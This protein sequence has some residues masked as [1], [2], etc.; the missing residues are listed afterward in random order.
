MDYQTIPEKS[1]II[2]K[3]PRIPGYFL[4]D[5]DANKLMK[6]Q[7]D[8]QA[9]NFRRNVMENYVGVELEEMSD[10]GKSKSKASDKQGEIKV[11]LSREFDS[12]QNLIPP[13]NR[14][15]A[16]L[17]AREGRHEN[18]N[19]ILPPRTIRSTPDVDAQAIDQM[20]SNR[21]S[22]RNEISQ[23]QPPVSPSNE[24]NDSAIQAPERPNPALNNS[25]NQG[26]N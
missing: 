6:P 1:V 11:N 7:G 8:K 13:S 17:S 2:R 5:K 21:I 14:R 3:G 9:I 16:Y 4:H 25:G 19:I 24:R 20:P 22:G 10:E 15:G 18:L 23:M 26:R 12:N